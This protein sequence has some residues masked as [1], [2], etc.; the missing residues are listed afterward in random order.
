MFMG[1]ITYAPEKG[2]LNARVAF[3]RESSL[4]LLKTSAIR[5]SYVSKHL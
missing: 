2:R 5:E 3:S 4:N 1:E